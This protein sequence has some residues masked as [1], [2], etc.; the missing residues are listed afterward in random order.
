MKAQTQRWC[1]EPQRNTLTAMQ[2]HRKSAL[3]T[4]S[5]YS[6]AMSGKF[7]ARSSNNPAANRPGFRPCNGFMYTFTLRLVTEVVG[8]DLLVS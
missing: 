2:L 6:S 3:A 8:L 1:D 7:P 4:Q 5:H